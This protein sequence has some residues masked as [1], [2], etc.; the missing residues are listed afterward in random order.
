[1]SNPKVFFDITIGG[2]AAGRI[3]FEVRTTQILRLGT[4]GC[5]RATPL[6]L[7]GIDWVVRVVWAYKN[8]LTLMDYLV[9]RSSTLT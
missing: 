2:N 5:S 8:I 6:R 7:D 1:M 3:V 9:L 4:R